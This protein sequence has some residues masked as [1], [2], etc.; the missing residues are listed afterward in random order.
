MPLPASLPDLHSLLRA[1]LQR[2]QALASVSLLPWA[3]PSY[4]QGSTR[5]GVSPE[6]LPL[7]ALLIG[8]GNYQSNARLDNPAM[9]TK[10]I[11]DA[12]RQRGAHVV[13]AHD[14]SAAALQQRIQQFIQQSSRTPTTLW[15]GYSGHAVQIGGR[16]FLQ[17]VDSDFSTAQRVREFGVEL[18]GVLQWLERARPSAAVVSIDACRNNPFEPER[19][20][21]QLQG[22]AAQ[23]PRGLCVSFS[24]APY[25]RALDGE[26]GKASPYAQALAQSL[27]GDKATSL[28]DLLRMTADK[29]YQHTARRQIPEYR[30]A[31][32][33]HWWFEGQGVR[34]QA[35]DSGP[36]Q[37]LPG[38]A[39]SASREVAYRPDEPSAIP[40]QYGQRSLHS[41]DALEHAVDRQIQN[42]THSAMRQAM[43]RAVQAARHSDTDVQAMPALVSAKLHLEGPAFLQPDPARGRQH[44]LPWANQGHVLAQTWLGESF[45]RS[46]IFDQSYKWNALAA[47]SGYPR[48]QLNVLHLSML[49]QSG[50]PGAQSPEDIALKLKDMLF[51]PGR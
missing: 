32:R 33:A 44:L 19:T 18:D 38:L 1:R 8:N 39:S 31:L 51:G 30:S 27:Q 42:L 36:A 10:V 9:D 17:G 26:A 41:W 24:T 28:D 14:L 25:T 2:R 3:G 5:A 47:R 15:I 11:G 20:R 22:L 21:S 7:K 13:Y 35:L 49:G 43:R 50:A 12:L 40:R 29:V 45:F 23:S 37:P 48:A 4:S 46:Q 34:L 16:N 6:V